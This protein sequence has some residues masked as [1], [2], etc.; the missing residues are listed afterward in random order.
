MGFI[1]VLVRHD[2]RAAWM[3]QEEINQVLLTIVSLVTWCI[4]TIR[5]F[6]AI[7]EIPAG[8][9]LWQIFILKG[10]EAVFWLLSLA[11]IGYA[12]WWL[13]TQCTT[14]TGMKYCPKCEIEYY[15]YNKCPYCSG[16]K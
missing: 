2:V 15:G 16:G 8:A 12:Q 14:R 9:S 11:V 13:D 6:T 1:L 5:F 3:R 7:L 4:M 10:P